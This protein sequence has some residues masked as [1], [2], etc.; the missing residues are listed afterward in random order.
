MEDDQVVSGLVHLARTP[1]PERRALLTS[2]LSLPTLDPLAAVS[3]LRRKYPDLDP[4]VGSALVTQQQLLLAGADKGL[5]DATGLWMT[6]P[7]GLEQASRPQVAFRRA[8]LLA[9]A[10]VRSVV[11]ATAG[12]GM[13][14][15]AFA[16]RGMHVIAVEK[17]PVTSEVC[18]ANLTATLSEVD[19]PASVIN[20]DATEPDLLGV[21]AQQLPAPVAVFVD[22]SRRGSTR[23]IDGS[24]ARPE[25]DPERWSPP[26]SF[27]D[28]LRSHFDFVAAKAP[29]SFVPSAA[30][31]CEWLGVRDHIV[32][33]SVYST[34]PPAFLATHQA[35][36]L[37]NDPDS[38]IT[39]AADRPHAPSHPSSHPS[40]AQPPPAGPLEDYLGEPHPVFRY[41]LAALCGTTAHVVHPDSHWITS[42]QPTIEG[43]RWYRLLESVPVTQLANAAHNHGIDALAIKCR[44]SR[45]SLS[46]LRES[47]GLPDGNRYAV[48]VAG[49]LND[50]LLV[51][52]VQ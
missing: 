28:S 2:A 10:G 36:L 4:R 17:D 41:S 24:R 7:V 27:V 6:T 46:E 13:D 11:D 30:W 1:L 43:V 38:E 26:W 20:A 12:I 19:A 9:A 16:R 3:T 22:P 14:S 39:H 50:A 5:I 29:G 21:L 33:C 32:E 34:A 31:A 44:E 48:V 40:S 45:R 52:R 23:P 37:S 18:A 49:G 42:A 8:S 15:H 51:E 35:T 47:I 25:R